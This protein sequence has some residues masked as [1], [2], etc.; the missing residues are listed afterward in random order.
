MCVLFRFRA[1]T[2]NNNSQIMNHGEAQNVTHY[3]SMNSITSILV[4][5]FRACIRNAWTELDMKGTKAWSSAHMLP[6]VAVLLVL[7]KNKT[8]AWLTETAANS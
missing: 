3:M 2:V 8:T 7:A 1:A 5:G 4:T 6:F